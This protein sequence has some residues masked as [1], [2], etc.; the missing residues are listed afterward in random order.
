MI[1]FAHARAVAFLLPMW[2]FAV[3][4]L[5]PRMAEATTLSY[6]QGARAFNWLALGLASATGLWGGV[7]MLILAL[8]MDRRVVS[9]VLMEGLRN[10][11]ASPI[12][13]MGAYFILEALRTL[14]WF[15]ASFEVSFGVITIAGMSA[16]WL[17]GFVQGTA[18]EAAPKVRAGLIDWILARLG[19]VRK[20]PEGSP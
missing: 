17:V 18:T 11:V 2:V 1:K 6:D 5:V 3:A 14:K 7:L 8:A 12:T 13:G 4:W 19:A 15:D 16:V 20:P 9:Q 10:A